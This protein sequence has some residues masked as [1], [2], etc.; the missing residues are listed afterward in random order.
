MRRRP[1]GS[2]SVAAAASGRGALGYSASSHAEIGLEAARRSC[3]LTVLLATSKGCYAA[4]QAKR[5]ASVAC[6]TL[7]RLGALASKAWKQS[8]AA[9]NWIKPRL[10]TRDQACS[11]KTSHTA[12]QTR[13]RRKTKTATS[14]RLEATKGEGTPSTRPQKMND[15][16]KLLLRES[17]RRR[18]RA[19]DETA[20]RHRTVG[21]PITMTRKGQPTSATLRCLRNAMPHSEIIRVRTCPLITQPLGYHF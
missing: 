16:A 15:P 11:E 17:P 1:R 19:L 3:R 2:R 7:A 6:E 12:Q 8:T 9:Q 5:E 20:R 18:P 21:P 10:D 4:A 13:H 14:A